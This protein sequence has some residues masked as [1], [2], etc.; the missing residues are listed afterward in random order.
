MTSCDCDSFPPSLLTHTPPSYSLFS[1]FTFFAGPEAAA[2]DEANAEPDAEA[3]RDPAR[4]PLKKKPRGGAGRGAAARAPAPVG[5]DGTTQAQRL[6]RGRVI[7][8]SF[9]SKESKGYFLCE[10]S[11]TGEGGSVVQCIWCNVALPPKG[12]YS[13]VALARHTMQNTH[14]EKRAAGRGTS[15][16]QEIVNMKHRFEEL[17]SLNPAAKKVSQPNVYVQLSLFLSVLLIERSISSP[18]SP[19]DD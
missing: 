17:S 13:V 3:V 10:F 2:E 16:A 5:T 4:S 8:V 12:G 9:A 19:M 14:I 6:A 15:V 7:Q 1:L 11:V 18:M